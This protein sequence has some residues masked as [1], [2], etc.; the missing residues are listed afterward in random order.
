MNILTIEINE[1]DYILIPREV[2]E[3][4]NIKSNE[5]KDFDYS[6]DEVWRGLKKKSVKAYKELKEREFKIR[7]EKN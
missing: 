6:E 5:P 2:R 7:H 1:E 4:V 3:R